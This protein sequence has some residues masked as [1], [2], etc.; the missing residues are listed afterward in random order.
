MSLP[1]FNRAGV[2][3]T[4]AGSSY[5]ILGSALASGI[6]PYLCSFITFANS[7]VTGG[8]SVS[9]LL[10][11][12]NGSWELGTT[13]YLSS[14]TS[15][16]RGAAGVTISS[17]GP[18]VVSTSPISLSGNAQVFISMRAEDL[19]NATT[20]VAGVSELATDAETVTGTDTVRTVTP[21]N[22]TAAVS[23]QGRQ[24]IFIPAA[25]MISRTT[26]GAASGSAEKTTNKNMI[27]SLDFDT[28]TQ[29]F[30]QFEVWFPKSWNLG[31]VTFQPM[32]SHAATT[33]NFGVVFQLAGIA[34]SNDDVQDVAFGTAQTSTDTGGTTDDLYI[35]PESSAITIGGTPTAEDSVLFQVARVPAD[36][37]D[38][39]AVDARLQGIRLFFTTNAATD[40]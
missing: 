27:K 5:I 8:S 24:T 19:V 9:Y 3:S 16:Q 37:S 26:N 14:N 6:S 34:R 18:T 35:G 22:L 28:T 23:K 33:V 36:G 20:S 40:A 32:W 21:S 31:T 7:G 1:L 17:T 29:E 4:T 2:A 11:D 13:T 12:S 15:L 10:L 38:T 25:A 30:A 39:L